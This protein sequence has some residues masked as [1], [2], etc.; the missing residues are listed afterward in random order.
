MS[1][2]PDLEQ[3]RARIAENRARFA[4]RAASIRADADLNDAAKGRKIREEHRAA[5]EEHERLFREYRDAKQR[6]GERLRRAAFSV[7]TPGVF[8]AELQALRS[9]HALAL[10]RAS[11]AET[12]EELERLLRHAATAQ[13]Q[14][15]AL[16]V[17]SV[18]YD[19]G[20]GRVLDAFLAEHPER[21]AALEELT[22]YQ[23]SMGD[24]AA[25][26]R[27]RLALS[28]PQLPAGTP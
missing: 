4:H 15:L 22:E 23:A 20:R 27:D 21:R 17:A 11:Q 7:R 1:T 13:D 26:L 9:A 14:L 10:D 28:G 8:G 2:Y 19:R 3:L 24:R 25:D 6:V 5:A 18:A 16:S 12:D